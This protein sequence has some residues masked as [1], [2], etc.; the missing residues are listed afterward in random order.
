MIPCLFVFV[1]SRMI[2]GVVVVFLFT[3]VINAIEHCL[4][5]DGLQT[6]GMFA[7][8]EEALS[9]TEAV[10]F[11]QIG[12][13]DGVMMDPLHS[14]MLASSSRRHRWDG[15]FV[16]PVPNMMR[17]LKANKATVSGLNDVGYVTAVVNATCPSG[18]IVPFFT[19]ESREGEPVYMQGL[20]SLA[21]PV[22]RD[23]RRF[24]RIAVS[25]KT[26]LQLAELVTMH[27]AAHPHILLIDTEGFDIEI[28]LGFAANN[29]PFGKP[30]VIA[31][32][33]WEGEGKLRKGALDD[34]FRMF[35]TAGYRVRKSVEDGEDYL[36]LKCG[37]V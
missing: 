23:P 26:P 13:N 22:G 29:W 32:E 15:L 16:E 18:G 11:V 27:N 14:V 31:F 4:S 17:Q 19:Y 5:S 1:L 28:L 21:I 2:K 33:V 10:R 8:I 30:N 35:A 25:C 36:A 12:A 20:G 37:S 34:M 24:R 9:I 3:V 6:R 7:C